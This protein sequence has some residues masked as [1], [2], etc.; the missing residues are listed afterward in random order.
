MVVKGSAYIL[1]FSFL[2]QIQAKLVFLDHVHINVFRKSRCGSI[3]RLVSSCICSVTLVEVLRF[4]DGFI[5]DQSL[6]GLVDCGVG[7]L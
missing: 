7:F 1:G 5:E 2:V 4:V 3:M 6:H